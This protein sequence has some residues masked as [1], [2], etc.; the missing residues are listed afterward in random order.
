MFIFPVNQSR[1]LNGISAH[2]FPGHVFIGTDYGGI[3][4]G[5]TV[6][7]DAFNAD[8][9]SGRSAWI[10]VMDNDNDG[11]P[12]DFKPDD[13]TELI[14]DFRWDW[15]K[16]KLYYTKSPALAVDYFKNLSP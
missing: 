4:E 12:I 16:F 2:L 15:Y 10:I 6:S 7:Y 5:I 13:G 3:F 9:Y 8:A 11:K 1:H 14:G